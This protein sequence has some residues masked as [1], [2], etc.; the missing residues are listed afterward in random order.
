ML[1][2]LVFLFLVVLLSSVNGSIAKPFLNIYVL[3]NITS[4]LILVFLA[5]LP[6]GLLATLLAPKLGQFIDKLN[7]RVAI[8]VS[9]LIGAAITWLVINTTNIWFFIILTLVDYTIALSGGLIFRNLVSR[10]NIEHRGKIMGLSSFFTNLG[11]SAGPILGGIA[12]DALGPKAPFIVSI[13]VELSL[14][15][16][17]WLIYYYLVPHLAERYSRSGKN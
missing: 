15:P 4:D 6:S 1:I 16:V 11:A 12:W 8:T 13:Y 2:G 5:Y 3:E 9:A 17:Y 7:P 10:V 14:I